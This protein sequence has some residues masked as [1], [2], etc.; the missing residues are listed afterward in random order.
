MVESKP[1]GENRPQQELAV[2]AI[3]HAINNREHLI[4]QAGTGVGK[5]LSYAI[6]S[7][8]SGKKVTFSTAT[9]QLS[10][11]AM[12][13]DIPVLKKALRDQLGK[14]FK[15]ALLKGRDNY[16]CHY[17]FEGLKELDNSAPQQEGLFGEEAMPIASTSEE[18]KK[19]AKEFSDF[20][21]WV[22]TTETGDRSD[23]PPVSDRTWSAVSANNNECIGKSV[24]PFGDVCFAEKARDNA[25][26]AQVVITNHAISAL[27]LENPDASLM[28]EREVFV[29]DEIHELD[30]YLSSSWGT[31]ITVK[32]IVDVLQLAK[33]QKPSD[34][35]QEKSHITSLENALDALQ[36]IESDFD[37]LQDGLFKENKLPYRLQN[38]LENM[39]AVLS[40]LAM[41]YSPESTNAA[42]VKTAKT[43]LSVMESLALVLDDSEDTVR[44]G[45]RPRHDNDK[46]PVSLNCAPLRIGPRLMSALHSKD[47][48]MIGT[49]AT[50]TV[51]GKFDSPVRNF[52]LAEGINATDTSPGIPPRP[53]KA[54]DVGTPFDYPRQGMFYLPLSK[55]FPS[56]EWKFREEHAK[57][58]E[59]E[60]LTLVRAAGGRALILTTQD[61]RI[62]EI[63]AYLK[64]W[65][66]AN[67][68]VLQQGDEPAPQL[69]EKF[70]EDETSV[71]VATMGMWHGLDIPGPACSLVVMD[72]IPF[73]P[74]GDP[75][76]TARQDYVNKTGGNGF[77]EVYVAD[78]NV[79]LAQGFG[80]LIRTMS[81]KGVVAV[82]DTR[83]R[84][85]AYGR[86]MLKSLPPMG[87]FS[88][89][90]QVVAAL[91][92]L[93]SK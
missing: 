14:Y 21:N 12:K 57:A 61:K 93:T 85:K 89:L 65:L 30:N 25:R 22:E 10:E 34:A 82:L 62:K 23:A 1:G 17:K 2:C 60:T 13:K 3:E 31:T 5:T 50:I 66:P 80:R 4:I 11:Q 49:S 44:W 24:C 6:P 27:E 32:M 77:I 90:D 36:I 16:A 18:G 46:T 76:A 74:Q 28:G 41:L 9:K 45:R 15:A 83:L 42:E 63:G 8:L 75:L 59:E 68:N 43:L 72:K 84:D 29:F 64:S 81:D 87:I 35:S 91:K 20:F 48:L 73:K 52:G 55:N 33:K 92:R 78:A 86:E 58:V 47:A 37:E 79:K 26:T 40:R 39:L 71:L 67:I 19:M 53:F 54:L 7:I 38:A 51:A 56:A 69:I 70:A 88:D